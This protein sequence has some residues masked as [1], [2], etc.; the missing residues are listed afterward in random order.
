MTIYVIG[1]H[2]VERGAR[3]ICVTQGEIYT[4]TNTNTNAKGETHTNKKCKI[5]NIHANC[6]T[7]LRLTVEIGTWTICVTRREGTAPIF[8]S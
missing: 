4:N 2:T 1:S 5:E 7:N 6:A 3:T 8:Q